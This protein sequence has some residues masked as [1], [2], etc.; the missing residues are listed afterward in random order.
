M[1][2]AVYENAKISPTDFQIYVGL[3]HTTVIAGS[4]FG[5]DLDESNSA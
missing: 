2:D 4:V 3:W 5:I 1:E